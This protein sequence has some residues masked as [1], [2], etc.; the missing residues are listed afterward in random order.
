L[1]TSDPI[2]TGLR[3]QRKMSSTKLPPDA[4]HL[5]NIESFEENESNKEEAEYSSD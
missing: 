2:I 4:I 5:L 3:P 1:I